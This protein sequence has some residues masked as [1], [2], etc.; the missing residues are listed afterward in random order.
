MCFKRF[1]T[2]NS[3]S[4]R[5][6]TKVVQRLHKNVLEN[7]REFLYKVLRDIYEYN[8]DINADIL[9]NVDE[10]PIVLELLTERL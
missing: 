9:A 7:V 1:R 4:I 10:T 2:R 8:T 5:R 3:Y 6:I